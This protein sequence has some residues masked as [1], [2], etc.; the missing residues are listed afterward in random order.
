VFDAVGRRPGCGSTHCIDRSA[1]WPWPRRAEFAYLEMMNVTRRCADGLG[2]SDHP[3]FGWART[4][5]CAETSNRE[6]HLSSSLRTGV[7]TET[8]GP[9]ECL[10]YI[11]DS[12]GGHPVAKPWSARR[13]AARP[14]SRRMA[15]AAHIV[16]VAMRRTHRLSVERPGSEAVE[17]KA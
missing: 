6:R 5:A 13:D 11:L 17:L 3:A 12:T 9:L 4:I 10:A 2:M 7:R 14:R 1:L 15:L 8:L 16:A